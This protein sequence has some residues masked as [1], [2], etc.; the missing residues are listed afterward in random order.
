MPKISAARIMYIAAIQIVLTTIGFILYKRPYLWSWTALK[1]YKE[2]HCGRHL[3]EINAKYQSYDADNQA[4]SLAMVMR[5]R[6]N[7]NEDYLDSFNDQFHEQ[8]LKKVK[9][10]FVQIPLVSCFLILGIVAALHWAPFHNKTL[11]KP[12]FVFAFLFSVILVSIN[13]GQIVSIIIPIINP[14]A[15]PDRELEK[16]RREVCGFAAEILAM[17]LIIFSSLLSSLIAAF[18]IKLYAIRVRYQDE[19]LEDLNMGEGRHEDVAITISTK[20]QKKMPMAGET[21]S[22]KTGKTKQENAGWDDGK[23]SNGWGKASDA[24]SQNGWGSSS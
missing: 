8:C 3:D 11:K 12:G 23:T 15:S 16:T 5:Y 2:V 17:A 10:A 18:V 4:K 14:N 20:T 21:I 19:H 7:C 1:Y 9:T 6:S 13:I 24:G 22:K